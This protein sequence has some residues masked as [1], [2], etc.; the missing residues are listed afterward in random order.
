MDTQKSAKSPR[1]APREAL[2][3][4]CEAQFKPLRSPRERPP[5]S[6]LLSPLLSPL[7]I[8]PLIPS[9]FLSFSPSS[10]FP[11]KKDLQKRPCKDF[12]EDPARHRLHGP[13]WPPPRGHARPYRPGIDLR[14]LHGRLSAGGTHRAPGWF[15]ATVAYPAAVTGQHSYQ[16]R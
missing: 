6:L 16:F 12:R 1:E 13:A 3:A 8:P 10:R 15:G 5:I 11:P 7:I 4:P 9:F 14:G 2:R